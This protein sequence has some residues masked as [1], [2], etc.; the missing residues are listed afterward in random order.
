M[1]DE[2]FIVKQLVNNSDFLKKQE[3]L[4][5]NSLRFVKDKKVKL[6]I[7]TKDA[8]LST[9]LNLPSLP[10]FSEES[11][12]NSKL[13]TLKDFNLFSNDI[14]L[15]NIDE[16]YDSAKYIN[17]VYYINY[18]NIINKFFNT[19]QPISYTT[20]FDNFRSDYEDAYLYLDGING[21]ELLNV[22]NNFDINS[23]LRL[24]NPLKLR[25]STKNAMVTFNAI[26]K[27]FRSRFDEGRSNARL[28]DFSNSYVKHPFITDYRINYES[29]LGKNRESY[30]Q[31]NLYNHFNKLNFSNLILQRYSNNIYFMELPFLLSMKSDPS[32][33]LWFDWQSK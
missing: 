14:I 21:G 9:S 16:V 7:I 30:L 11:F 24:S 29:L 31:A 27:V 3:A 32:R 13:L 4:F 2:Y 12:T 20:I 17:Y 5:N 19:F 28:E 23:N 18:K 15:E 25:S 10:I 26:Q 1:H 6:G 8:N 33:Y 22:N